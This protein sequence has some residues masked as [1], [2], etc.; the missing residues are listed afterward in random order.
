MHNFI[1]SLLGAFGVFTTTLAQVS[2]PP[3]ASTALDRIANA[4]KPTFADVRE[5]VAKQYE[6]EGPL[7]TEKYFHESRF[8]HHYDDRFA[9]STLPEEQVIPHLI[10]LV[11]AYLKTM[12]AIGAETWIMHGTLLAWW[13]N[14]KI[15]PWDN[16]LD[17][18]VT[19]PTIHFLAD[20]HNFTDHHF[21]IPGVD[22]GRT[23]L[24]EINPNHVVKTT[25]DWLNVIDGRWIDKSS[26]LFYRHNRDKHRYKESDIFSST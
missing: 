3:G 9:N 13:W 23:Y 16:D 6:E 14:Q 2:T 21:E 4:N 19:E 15:F 11:Q 1:P 8:H 22:G 26:G 25:E 7:P 24:L 12:R 5:S 17:V 10:A 20:Y 18:Q